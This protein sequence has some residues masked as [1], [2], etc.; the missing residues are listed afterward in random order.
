MPSERGPH[1]CLGPSA[2]LVP[3]PAPQDGQ[4][5]SDSALSG[6]IV[7]CGRAHPGKEKRGSHRQRREAEADRCRRRCGEQG[8]REMEVTGSGRGPLALEIVMRSASVTSIILPIWWKH[9][10]PS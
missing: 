7:I 10:A 6:K 1:I 2:T 8:S 5:G 3:L 4:T 9:K